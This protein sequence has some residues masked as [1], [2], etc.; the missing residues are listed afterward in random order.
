MRWTTMVLAVG[1]LVLLLKSEAR[2][3]DEKTLLDVY[4]DPLPPGAM[5]RFG[6]LRWRLPGAIDMLAVS[7][8]GTQVAAVNMDGAVAVWE[9]DSGRPLHEIRGSKAGEAS[10]AFSPDGQLLATGGRFD[11][12]TGTG[13][14][15]VRI[16]DLKTGKIKTELPAQNGEIS[17]LVFTSDGR[18]LFS[19]GFDQPVIAWKIPEGDKLYAFPTEEY[20]F[21]D[22]AISPNDECVA[23]SDN[24][25]KTV[26]V[27]SLDGTRK[28]CKVKSR[29][30]FFNRLEFA[31]DGKS[32]VT[33]EQGGV[34][35]WEV[36]SGKLQAAIPLEQDSFRKAYLSPD[37]KKMALIGGDRRDISWLDVAAGK[38]LD[39]WHG[40]A[41]GFDSLAFSHDG[42]TVV[43][44]DWGAVRVWDASKGKVI[45]EPTGPDQICYALAFSVD[46]KT[47]LAASYNALYFLDGKTL[48][49]RTRIPVAMDRHDYPDYRFSVVLSPDGATAAFLG[50]KDEIVLMDSR[51]SDKVQTLRR[52][53]W[54]PASLAFSTDGA[55]LYALGHK[56][57][58]L[59]VW[60]L[61]TGKESISPDET[62]QPLSNLSVAHRGEKLAVVVKGAEPRC[63]LWDL[64]TEKEQTSLKLTDDPDKIMLSDD[65]KLLVMHQHMS[66]YVSIW[67]VA[68][69]VELRRIDIGAGMLTWAFS[70]DG[71]FLVTSHDGEVIRTWRTADGTKVAELRGHRG[72]IVALAL[73][74][75]DG[76]LV[77]GCTECTILRWQKRAWQGK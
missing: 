57:P 36:A 74:P 37:G 34:L 22:V 67:D 64:R 28:L 16:W 65:G 76:G 30:N 62:L 13:D 4:G 15:R 12:H 45:Q 73:S 54:S 47:A 63:R 7:P 23:V 48:K 1:F 43:T 32:L 14:F 69:G 53:D 58:G 26:T 46:G 52:P 24:D 35:I 77:S 29:W 9:K 70:D 49:E 66:N 31:P 40:G 61:K 72:G 75:E 55:R 33:H 18:T 6:S 71:C 44:A 5:A 20:T 10:L 3:S 56:S 11:N 8:D 39:A 50:R 60:D 17:R 41:E 42:K 19:A 38:P 21:H 59:R 25:L 68:K 2:C 51:N 27:Y